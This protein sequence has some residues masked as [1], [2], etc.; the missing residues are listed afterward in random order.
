MENKN[1][2]PTKR[3]SQQIVSVTLPNDA[4]I[5]A[6]YQFNQLR[7]YSLTEIEM[8]EWARSI[9]RLLPDLDIDALNFLIDKM[10]TGEME[11]DK[12]VGIQNIFN[13]MKKIEKTESGYKILKAIW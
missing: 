6:V 11:Y 5:R 3:Q 2:L 4:I 13:G 7:A 8:M 10:K 9:E 1:N 12:A